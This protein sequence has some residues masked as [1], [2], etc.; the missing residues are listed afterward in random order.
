MLLAKGG[1]GVE[2]VGDAQE[3]GSVVVDFEV[4][5][6]LRDEGGGVFVEEHF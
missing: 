1:E 4:G 3:R 6:A 2:G 5:G